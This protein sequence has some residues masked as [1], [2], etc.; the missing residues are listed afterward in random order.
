[1]AYQKFLIAPFNENSGLQKEVKPWI[2]PDN[3]FAQLDN[4][5][6]FRGRVRKR[7]GTRWMGS[8]Q[9]AS[10]FRVS[11]GLTDGSG[12]FT[13]TTPTSAPLTPYVAGAVGQMFSIG[14]AVYTVTALGTPANLLRS[15]GVVNT[16]TYN[17]TTGAVIINGAAATTTVY[18]YPALP[19][20][21]LPLYE[22]AVINDEMTVGF[23]THFA[24]QYTTTGWE[25]LATESVAGDAEWQGT[26]SDFFWTTTWISDP[27]TRI[28]F[29]TNFNKNE[30]RAMRQFDGTT[31]SQF[32]P[33]ISATPN[34][35]FS[36]RILVVFKNRLI[37][38][39]TWE[40]TTA[41]GGAASVNIPNRCRYAAYGSPLAADAWNQDIKGNGN[42]IDA[43]TT[44]A[45]ITVEFV[46][47][48][49]IVYFESS[50]WELAYTGNQAVPFAWYQI[51][52]ELGAESTFSIIPFDNVALGVGNVGI[53]S[54]SGTNVQRIDQKI[55]NEVFDI[56]QDG[57]GIYRVYGIR[58]YRVE[59]VYWTFPSGNQTSSVYYP[60]R[61]LI[62][63]YKTGTWAFNDDSITCFG[64]YFPQAGVTWDSDTVTWDE[65]ISWDSGL[66]QARTQMI[67]AG[68]QEGYVSIVDTDA[69]M[70]APMLQITNIS[71]AA[72]VGGTAVTITCINHN[73]K[74]NDYVY[75]SGIIGTNVSVLNDASYQIVATPNVLATFTI[76]YAG[77]IVSADYAGNGVI[78]RISQVRIQTKEFNFFTN[79]ESNAALAQVNFLVDRTD[80]GQIL[81][82][83]YCSSNQ[84][85]DMVT[86]SSATGTLIGTSVLETSPYTRVPFESTQNRIWH[87]IYLQAQGETVQLNMYF[88]DTMMLDPTVFMQPFTLHAMLFS[89]YKAGRLQ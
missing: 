56:H 82:D 77:T 57:Q 70:N 35:L 2:I 9:L 71:I 89:F 5:Y 66:L 61:V 87:P 52:T 49:L 44:Q 3:A 29:V 8:T 11:L 76:I 28:F 12:N 21:G 48:R 58:D 36:A 33:T 53:H 47:D 30:A 51:N 14:T 83:F 42:F 27:Q 63:N 32:L 13:G 40:G 45:I 64:Y 6:V 69:P 15:D 60:D 1:M 73:L 65:D 85:I 74:V 59:M 25:R 39:N 38:L 43:A 86:Q 80:S 41:G 26:D 17:T 81:I 78:A 54:C 68:N 67:L 10:R 31:W 75:L 16:A 20:M 55:P 7:F 24:Y 62:Y 22:Q 4:V 23:D 84:A 37:A 79:Q 18:F 72:I 19:V 50:T 34:S 46:R 88:N